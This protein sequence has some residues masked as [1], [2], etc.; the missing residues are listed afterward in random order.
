MA[1][2]PAAE[3][4]ELPESDR[5]GDFP[6]PR[7][8]ERLFGHDHAERS[9]ATAFASGRMHHG[10]LLI[11][12]EGV[13]KATLAWRLARHVLSPPDERDSQARSLAIRSEAPAVRQVMALSHPG[14]LLIRRPYDVR[15]KRFSASIP[16]DEVR[17]LRAFLAHTAGA[18]AWRI[19]IVDSADDLNA[20][21]ANAL[22]KSLEEPPA[23]TLFVLVSSQPGRLL[24]TIRSRCR[25]LELGPVRD[26]ALR[27]AVEAALEASEAPVPG[28]IDWTQL[29]R[30]SEGSVRQSLA[31]IANDGLKMQARIETLLASLPNLDWGSAHKLGDELSGV[32]NAQKFETFFELLLGLVAR[33]VRTRASGEG[34]AGDQALAQRLIAEHRL[35]TWAELWETIVRDKAEAQTLNLDRKA[36]ILETLSR[37]EQ[38]ARA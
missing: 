22:L 18:G 37:I 5:L 11:G 19:V 30:L 23:R 31:L 14:L 33:L 21:S 6:H 38:S 13:G 26:Q 10:W 2:A 7:A 32:A 1:R 16:V 4:E 17:R 36:L 15:N 12:P 28:S 25:T 3:I 35:A 9:L 27:K 29:E 34:E 24:P 8:T 20:S